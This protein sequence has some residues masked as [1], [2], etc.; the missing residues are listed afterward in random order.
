M[1]GDFAYHLFQPGNLYMEL[2]NSDA[3][4]GGAEEETAETEGTAT[5]IIL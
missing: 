2:L 1:C 4:T 5:S 3:G